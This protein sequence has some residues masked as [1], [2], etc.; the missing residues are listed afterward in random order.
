[1]TYS[2]FS[3][4]RRNFRRPVFT[5]VELLVVIAIIAILA[6]LLLPA[7]S[8]AREQAQSAACANNLRQIGLGIRLYVDDNDGIIPNIYPGFDSGSIPVLRMPMGWVFALGKLIDNYQLPAE[9][10]GCPDNPEYS[11][12][13]VA[14]AWNAPGIVWSAYLYR[15][16][17]AGFEWRLGAPGNFGKAM[18][19][20]FACITAKGAQFAPHNYENCNIL[21]T[22]GHVENRRNSAEPHQFYTAEATGYSGMAPPCAEV[23]AHADLP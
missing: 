15:A 8:A 21:Y 6:G 19:I 13:R 14:A 3:T 9:V 16:V 17:D 23:W 2:S 20:D 7:L 1:M 10:F 4:G 22:D 11:E 12:A 5:L 18:V